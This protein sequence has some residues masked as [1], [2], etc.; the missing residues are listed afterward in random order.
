MN[1][2]RPVRLGIVGATGQVGEVMR[3]I[4]LER[5]FPVSDIRF[6]A[7]AR[8]AGT[9]IAWGDRE[10]VV[11]DAATADPSGLDIAL[12][13]AGGGISKALAPVF[14]AAGAVVVDNSSVSYTHLTLPTIC[15]V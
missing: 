14:A 6:F 3:R 5:G 1:A 12:F 8:S 13:S 15:S 4:L 2:P 10:V 7:S 9:T 11:E